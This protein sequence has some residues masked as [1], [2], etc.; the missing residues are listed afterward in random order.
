MGNHPMKGTQGS[1]MFLDDPNGVPFI[2]AKGSTVGLVSMILKY[3]T[4]VEL[5][6]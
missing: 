5:S 2:R 4:L 6:T 1:Q 3:G